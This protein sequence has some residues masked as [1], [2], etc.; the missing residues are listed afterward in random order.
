[1][2]KYLLLLFQLAAITL[3]AQTTNVSYTPHS[4][5]IPNPE[6]GFYHFT[7]TGTGSNYEYLDQ[8]ALAAL[9]SGYTSS[10]ANYTAP[11]TLIYRT[12]Y[13]KSFVNGPISGSFLSDMQTDFDIARNAGVKII[14]RFTYT[15]DFTAPYNDATK[16]IILGHLAQL[17]PVLS[18]NADVIATVQT[19]LIGTWGEWCATDYFGDVCQ[20]PYM[21]N[22]TNWTDRNEVVNALLAAV[23]AQRSIQIRTPRYK[24]KAVHGTSAPVTAAATG[25]RI[26]FHNDCFLAPYF[27]SGTFHDPDTGNSDTLHLKAYMQADA[28][29]NVPVGGETCETNGT[30]SRCQSAGGALERELRRFRYSFLN[31]DYNH[32][33]NNTWTPCFNTVENGL[34]YRFELQNGTYP[35]T[36][37]AGGA[38]NL[39]FAV[40]NVGFAQPYN[41]RNLQV[42]LRNTTT[43]DKW[44][45]PMNSNPQDWSPQATQN[46]NQNFCLPTGMP[47]GNYE[48]L[49]RLPDP[50]I[51][52]QDRPEYAI[53]LAN[54]G[55]WE[56]ATGF[57]KLNHT[58]SVSGSGTC[59]GF[60]FFTGS[61]LLGV[62][63]LSFYGQPTRQGNALFWSTGLEKDVYSFEVE[64]AE[65]GASFEPIGSVDPKGTGSSYS[66]VDRESGGKAYYYR[67]KTVD[68]DG[69]YSFSKTIYLASN[70]PRGFQIQPTLVSDRITVANNTNSSEVIYYR[71]VNTA[72]ATVR[73]GALHT[74]ELNT[75]DLNSGLYYLVLWNEV[76]S[77]SFT[78][79][80]M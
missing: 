17:A 79:V 44:T 60:T 20:A 30:W 50:E 8:A 3:A 9:R 10:G 74:L 19:G 13:L 7:H 53:Q 4:L 37:T 45:A 69:Q 11:V 26:G 5:M 34:G 6:R 28:A 24:Q 22:S 15:E 41:P 52:I 70:T 71:I 23:P 43:Q 59:S 31:A 18:A 64:R 46:I 32:S 48:L 16:A 49:L 61:A 33:V 76:A 12:F 63:Q 51:T 40:K 29:F 56:V 21:L 66:F 62:E 35:N 25:G 78:F 72:G 67:I 2:S 39:Q 54:T 73:D 38:I 65:N 58:L 1:M 57:N 77:G 68:N 42:I 14:A 27:D 55:V 80:R 75:A 47:A 36:A